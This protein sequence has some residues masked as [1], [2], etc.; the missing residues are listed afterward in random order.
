MNIIKELIDR[1]RAGE[2]IGLPCFCSANEHVLRS[3][4]SF[5]KKNWIPNSY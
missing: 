3:I 5:T 4:L 1:N 2:A